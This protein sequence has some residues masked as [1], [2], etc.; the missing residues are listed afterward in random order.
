MKKKI[1]LILSLVIVCICAIAFT[2]VSMADGED[3]QQET[4]TIS[5]MNSQDTTSDTTS[6]D[7]TAYAN[8]KQV[9]GVGE[10]FTLPTTSSNTYAAK[11][12][13]QLIW[14]TVDGRT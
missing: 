13:F 5:Y 1:S 10:K 8:G 14:Y 3:Q 4:I 12:G 9:V 11:E 7:T 2:V 6:L